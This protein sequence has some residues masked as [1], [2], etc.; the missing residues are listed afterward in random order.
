MHTSDNNLSN[1]QVLQTLNLS[2]GYKNKTVLRN[3][4]ISLY[5]GEVLCVLGPNGSGKSTL[6]KTILGLL[7][8]KSGDVYID[9][10]PIKHYSNLQIA[11]TL[12]YVPQ[13]IYDFFDFEVIQ[14]VLMGR[15]ARLKPFSNPASTDYEIAK[16]CLEQLNIGHLANRLY[17]QL[18]GGERQL[19]LIARA[20]AQQPQALIMD[21]PTSNLDFGN[22][23]RVLQIIQELKNQGLSILFCTHNP[24]HAISIADKVVLFKDGT[25]YKTGLTAEVIT[26][27]N[28]AHIYSLLPQQIEQHLESII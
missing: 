1:K 19:V 20:L 27:N 18:S 26:Q 21:E 4:S 12:A 6:F 14:V 28:L 7:P 23:I 9:N 5:Q 11:Q 8:I 10:K 25:I 22:Q 15:L 13:A 24:Q 17:T 2:V 3:I 16:Q